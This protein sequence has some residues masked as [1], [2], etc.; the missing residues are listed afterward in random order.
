MHNEESRVL[1]QKVDGY[2][3]DVSSGRCPDSLRGGPETFPDRNLQHHIAER[4]KSLG[5]AEI[6]PQMDERQLLGM[7]TAN[8]DR[9]RHVRELHV[10]R[11]FDEH[12]GEPIGILSL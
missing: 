7:Q 9:K 2:E 1:Q 3:T 8:K 10:L 5:A 4:K 6:V 11:G 12:S